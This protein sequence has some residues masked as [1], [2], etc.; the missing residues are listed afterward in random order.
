MVDRGLEHAAAVSSLLPAIESARS[1]W[2]RVAIEMHQLE[3]DPAWDDLKS[4]AELI[5]YLTNVDYEVK[6]LVQRVHVDFDNRGVWE[7]YLGLALFEGITAVPIV[8]GRVVAD[9]TRRNGRESEQVKRVKSAANSYNA[10]VKHIRADA[11]FWTLLGRL[12]NE[13]SAH[14]SGKGESPMAAH[15]LWARSVGYAAATG[16]VSNESKISHYAAQYVLATRQLVR[17]SGSPAPI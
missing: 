4:A 16:V 17:D 9:L 10:A 6:V 3:K 1:D 14:H 7:K 11:A 8:I 15:S 5:M 12:R 13:T 2:Q